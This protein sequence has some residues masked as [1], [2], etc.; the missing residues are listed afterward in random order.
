MMRLNFYERINNLVKSPS[1]HNII[2]FHTRM[3]VTIGM[4]IILVARSE[5]HTS[6]L[7]SRGHLV[8]INS[9]PTRRSSDL[10][11]ALLAFMEKHQIHP[12]VGHTFKLDEV[13]DAF[14]FLRENKQF[15]KIAIQT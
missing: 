11:K 10:L 15:G 1:K 8:Y 5:E 9:F 7:Q 4:M 14:E 2:S 13:N 3:I 6:E 12:V